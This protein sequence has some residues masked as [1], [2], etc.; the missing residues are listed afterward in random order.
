MTEIAIYLGV[1]G[2]RKDVTHG[3]RGRQGDDYWQPAAS[4]HAAAF[5]VEFLDS[6]GG[7]EA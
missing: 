1:A 6:I 4:G 2:G 3:G 7:T 5:V